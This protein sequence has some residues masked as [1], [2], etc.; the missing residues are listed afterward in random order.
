MMPA[1]S[2]PSAPQEPRGTDWQVVRRRNRKKDR[3]PIPP[4]P[5][6][7]RPDLADKMWHPSRDRYIPIADTA[8]T[9]R[10]AREF[11]QTPSMSQ[12]RDKRVGR[13]ED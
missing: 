9:L 10:A 8:K 12:F 7:C 2:I 5:P 13:N 6:P 11:N 3:S 1:E 4:S